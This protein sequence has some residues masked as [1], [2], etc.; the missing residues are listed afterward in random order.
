MNKQ[1]IKYYLRY[2]L[3]GCSQYAG[4]KRQAEELTIYT[5]VAMYIFVQ[6]NPKYSVLPLEL[7]DRLME[8]I[9]PDIM[10]QVPADTEMLLSDEKMSN[11]ASAMSK[12]DASSR[13]VLVL[14]HI[15]MMNTKE[16]SEVYNKSVGQI[17]TAIINSEKELAKNLD[18]LYPK[19][20]MHSGDDICLWLDEL[21]D[22]LGAEQKM[23][24]AEAVEKC[25]AEPQKARSMV[26]KYLDT[27]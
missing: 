7:I 18:Q 11:L 8:M 20:P 4:S 1:A 9:F 13:G 25:L 16:I 17:R 26:Q 5:L 2:T 22:A 24:L 14:Y 12:L 23:R 3:L 15:E 10:K 19:E 27:I 21:A 6:E